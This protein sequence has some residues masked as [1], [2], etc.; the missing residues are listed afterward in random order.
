MGAFAASR[1]QALLRLVKRRIDRFA[2][3][4]AEIEFAGQAYEIIENI[5]INNFAKCSAGRPTCCSTN[6]SAD[7]CA[8]DA[9]NNHTRRP[10]EHPGHGAKLRTARGACYTAKDACDRT[11]GADHS[12]CV[13]F[14]RDAS[15]PTS[16]APARYASILAFAECM[17]DKFG[18]A[19]SRL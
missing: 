4:L 11:Y 3:R 9:A 6:K 10:G 1:R 14:C 12:S 16:R 13:V 5:S 8:C 15:F 19:L 7:D 18:S 17:A 2:A